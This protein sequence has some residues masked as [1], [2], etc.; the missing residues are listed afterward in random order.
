M[1]NNRQSGFAQIAKPTLTLTVI[2][3][4]V[5]LLLALTN[6]L[7][8]AKIADNAAKKAAESRR[9]VLAADSYR[10]LDGEGAV[11]GAYDADGNMLGVTVVT[12]DNGYGGTIE[13]MTGITAD[14][15]VSGVHILSMSETPGLGARAKEEPFLSQYRGFDSPDLAVTKD[16]GRI[17]ALSGAT[18]SSRA[19]T[20]AVNEAIRI[21]RQYLAGVS[22]SDLQ[23]TTGGKE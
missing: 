1:E 19:V 13:V 4:I 22:A 10:Q 14:G 15:R 12:K 3:T 11:Y 8:S 16:G 18:I 2:C 9:L 20:R 5:T 23:S 7:T 21:S 6:M 17:D